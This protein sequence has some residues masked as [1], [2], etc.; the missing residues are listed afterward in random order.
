[1]NEDATEDGFNFETAPLHAADDDGD[2][3]GDGDGIDDD[4][5]DGASPPPQG[6]PNESRPSTISVLGT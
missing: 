3:D 2:G 1:M 6:V 4:D 5:D